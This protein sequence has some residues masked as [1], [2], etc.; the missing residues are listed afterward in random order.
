MDKTAWR[1]GAAIAIMGGVLASMAM[2]HQVFQ[3]STTMDSYL[4]ICAL[5]YLPVI[6]LLDAVAPLLFYY[7]SI[8]CWQG[9]SGLLWPN[10]LLFLI[11]AL[12]FVY[13]R[14]KG[15]KGGSVYVVWLTVLT[16]TIAVVMATERFD[17]SV[18]AV[19]LS[20]FISLQAVGRY[21]REEKTAWPLLSWG[22]LGTLVI[23]FICTY[24]G[25]VE[26]LSV[27]VDSGVLVNVLI[28]AMMLL[29]A[30]VATVKLY[31]KRET[32]WIYCAVLISLALVLPLLASFDLEEISALLMNLVVGGL[33]VGLMVMGV[34]E[35]RLGQTNMGL[36]VIC[37]LI[38]LRFFDADIGLLA[39]GV[40]FIVL[41]STFL[42]ANYKLSQRIKKQALLK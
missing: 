40:A 38:M 32:T 10:I 30:I 42:A 29:P 28:V 27:N 18:M 31:Q 36:G 9:S 25:G 5:L 37:L 33:G 26:M 19:L 14:V 15:K 11:L 24:D 23:L 1:E 3:L 8:V 41:G 16:A 35:N 21:F 34:K 17:L 4:L 20:F 7:V 12:P 13:Y 39:K 6:Y 22:N 2:V